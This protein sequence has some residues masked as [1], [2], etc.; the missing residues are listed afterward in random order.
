M[1]VV[2]TCMFAHVKT[3]I[4][5]Q[6]HVTRVD[7]IEYIVLWAWLCKNRM[8]WLTVNQHTMHA[9]F[10]YTCTVHAFKNLNMQLHVSVA[11]HPQ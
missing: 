11:F 4:I 10:T 3:G 1:R 5:L 2:N 8:W 9:T 7:N 6:L